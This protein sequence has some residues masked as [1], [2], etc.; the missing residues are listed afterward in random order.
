[1]LKVLLRARLIAT[2]TSLQ[3]NPDA[4]QRLG[5]CG[6]EP[7]LSCGTFHRRCFPHALVEVRHTGGNFSVRWL[8]EAPV[9]RI[10]GEEVQRDLPSGD[11]VF[12]RRW[13]E[14]I[15]QKSP[16][17]NGCSQRF[18]YLFAGTKRKSSIRDFLEKEIGSPFA[19]SE[20]GPAV[21]ATRDGLLDPELQVRLLAEIEEGAR[22]F[23]SISPPC[24]AFSR[25][26]NG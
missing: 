22:H 25:A 14:T 11:S 16:S 4:V 5:L 12:S 6:H 26:H 7:Y 20:A 10:Q 23:T 8:A 1:M 24:L 3:E 2:W 15:I 19:F 18:L 9:G 21:Q 13:L 17:A